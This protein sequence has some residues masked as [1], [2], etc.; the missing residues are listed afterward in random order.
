[1]RQGGDRLRC[2]NMLDDAGVWILLKDQLQM[3]RNDD[4]FHKTCHL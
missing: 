2:Q 1:M 4:R 3:P